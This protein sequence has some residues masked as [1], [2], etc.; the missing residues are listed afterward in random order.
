MHLSLD[1][2]WT[3]EIL[4]GNPESSRDYV[5]SYTY[6][7]CT[8]TVTVLLG[9][10]A[11]SVTDPGI[12]SACV[13][14]VAWSTLP[15]ILTLCVWHWFSSMR[16]FFF[17]KWGIYHTV[18]ALLTFDHSCNSTLMWKL[19]SLWPKHC[20]TGQSSACFDQNCWS[21]AA[22][23]ALFAVTKALMHS[24]QSSA[25]LHQSTATQ[26]QSFAHFGQSYK[27]RSMG[28]KL[29]LILAKAATSTA[30]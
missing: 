20:G 3:Q 24:Q 28:T 6:V 10:I 4:L 22:Q 23:W 16:V 12:C 27:H 17:F 15:K 14:R 25:H 8:R 13:G 5:F 29:L 21:I 1:R 18:K 30:A 7:N 9:V 26:W 2:L 11:W 19:R